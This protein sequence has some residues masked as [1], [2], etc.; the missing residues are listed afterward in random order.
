MALDHH[1]FSIIMSSLFFCCCFLL[2]I[3]IAIELQ[4]KRILLFSIFFFVPPSQAM[5]GQHPENTI[6]LSGTRVYPFQAV[7]N[8]CSSAA[9]L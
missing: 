6:D 9:V 8:L 1:N 2:C 4:I 3:V 7:I 5:E